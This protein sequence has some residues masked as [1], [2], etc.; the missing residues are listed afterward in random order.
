MSAPCRQ[1]HFNLG[2]FFAAQS[3]AVTLDAIL[4][5]VAQRG[6]PLHTH[7][8][9]SHEAHFG[10]AAPDWSVARDAHNFGAL[11]REQVPHRQRLS[12]LEKSFKAKQ[13]GRR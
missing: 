5:R 7:T 13:G 1:A 11:A 9:A 8:S 6:D 4:D 12:H 2:G 10:E 3:Q